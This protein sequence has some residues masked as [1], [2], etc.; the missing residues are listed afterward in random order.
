MKQLLLTLAI[1]TILLSCN[2][3]DNVTISVLNGFIGEWKMQSRVQNNNTPL[4]VSP[5]KLNFTEDADI[6][7]F[8]GNYEFTPSGNS[9]GNFNIDI[10]NT[11]VFNESNGN[12][13]T[14]DF[15]LNA[16][17]LKLSYTDENGDLI[18]EVWIKD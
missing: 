10:Y 14:Y 6:T 2:N 18:S 1:F 12:S 9:T 3:D 7:D 16:I 11:I 17:T 4:D 8:N 15:E 13:F 5:D